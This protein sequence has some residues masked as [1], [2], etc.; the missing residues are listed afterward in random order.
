MQKSQSLV[1]VGIGVLVFQGDA[2]L[3]G[4]RVGSHGSMTWA[5]PGGHLDFGETPEECA[6]RELLEETGL[7]AGTITRG[8]W[9]N[10]YFTK[11]GKH[12]ITLWMQVGDWQGEPKILEPTKCSQWRFFSFAH[13]PEPLFLSFDLLL[14]SGLLATSAKRAE[15]IKSN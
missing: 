1:R 5:P 3:L 14:R 13:L 6:A 11:E 15:V 10:D 2:V 7:K 12:Y 8:P 9:T 4:K